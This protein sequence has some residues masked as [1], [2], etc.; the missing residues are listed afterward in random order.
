MKLWKIA[1]FALIAIAS[2]CSIQKRPQIQITHVL[3]IDSQ[4]D[5]LRIP[6]DLRRPIK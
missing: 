5:T 2:S 3:A 6:I 1:L 4:G